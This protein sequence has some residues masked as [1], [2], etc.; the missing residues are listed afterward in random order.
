MEIPQIREVVM[1]ALIAGMNAVAANQ[2]PAG[3]KAAL[4]TLYDELGRKLADDREAEQALAELRVSSSADLTAVR[5][6]PVRVGLFRLPD[7]QL[8]ELLPPAW[9]VLAVCD[10]EGAASGRYDIVVADDAGSHIT[11]T[12]SDGAVPTGVRT[13]NVEVGPAVR[14]SLGLQPV[15]VPLGSPEA[16]LTAQATDCDASP[17]RQG[18]SAVS[19][20]ERTDLPLS[21]LSP[22]HLAEAVVV[23]ERMLAKYE[24]ELGPSH[25]AV[26]TARKDLAH[27]YWS[28][29]RTKQAIEV[30]ER[31]V[32]DARRTMGSNHGS[33]ASA[34]ETLRRWREG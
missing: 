25:P 8:R 7:D 27:L 28:S 26:I 14:G 24:R 20:S 29:G 18:T 6:H 12:R 31:A 15:D 9:R 21:H 32:M 30:L 2:P 17:P 19:G 23:A 5:L 10:P 34:E 33:T 13:T 22:R 4:W 1:A 16:A 11:G 3:L